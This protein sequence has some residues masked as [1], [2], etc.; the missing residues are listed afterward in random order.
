MGKKELNRRRQLWVDEEFKKKMNM[1][2]ATRVINTNG[3][4]DVGIPK[5]TREMMNSPLFKEL[6]KEL[7]RAREM[8]EKIKVKLDRRM[9]I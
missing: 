5:L 7:T 8:R 4:D 3:K 9:D 6:E 1:I 2:K